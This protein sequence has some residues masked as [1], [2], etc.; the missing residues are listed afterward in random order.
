MDT[1][2][3]RATVALKMAQK[4]THSKEMSIMNDVDLSQINNLNIISPQI[5]PEKR[6]QL[7]HGSF[8]ENRLL[9][10]QDIA[11]TAK[12]TTASQVS[13]SSKMEKKSSSSVV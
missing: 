3:S 7:D 11:T 2:N 1:G 5:R 13:R 4:K 6:H 10:L 9:L 8:T 12:P